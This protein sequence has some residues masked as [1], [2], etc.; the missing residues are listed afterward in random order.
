MYVTLDSFV[1]ALS[2]CEAREESV[3]Q[4]LQNENVLPTMG[5][6][7]T[8]SRLQDWR[9]FQ[10]SHGTILIVNSSKQVQSKNR[11]MINFKQYV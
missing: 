8:T 4:E 6:E 1:I 11:D 2:S 3:T 9:S 5:L 10:I 7:L